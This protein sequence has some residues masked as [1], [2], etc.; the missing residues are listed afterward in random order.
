MKNINIYKEILIIISLSIIFAFVRYLFI[1][2]S[3]E[4]VKSVR[5][6]TDCLNNIEDIN[7]SKE[8]ICISSDLAKLIYD[9]N[10]ALFID[11]RHEES[12]N[13]EHIENS[14]NLSFEEHVSD[15]DVDYIKESIVYDESDCFFDSFCIESKDSIPYIV[16]IDEE[17]QYYKNYVIY[18]DGEGC[19]YSH[20][21]SDFLYD[22]FGITN[23]LIYED[24][25]PIWKERGFPTKWNT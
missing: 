22:N 16:S 13:K 24:G 8:P 7:T 2:D 19:P 12:Y 18:C 23:I 25:I 17:K 5:E 21:L 15:L 9:K 14:I 20:D 1:Y 10:I 3:Y 4:L 11:A 6:K